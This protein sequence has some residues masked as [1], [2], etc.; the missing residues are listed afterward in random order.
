MFN[1]HNSIDNFRL[2]LNYRPAEQLG[3]LLRNI[4]VSR[5]SS[6]RPSIEH[7]IIDF[8]DGYHHCVEEG[9]YLM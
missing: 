5:I 9:H 6:T 8:R 3:L 4:V 2:N 7:R 1:C